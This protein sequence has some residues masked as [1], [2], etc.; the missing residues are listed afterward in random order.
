[1]RRFD[2]RPGLASLPAVAP[3]V[4]AVLAVVQVAWPLA[5][6]SRALLA[7]LTVVALAA[8]T[9]LLTTDAWG[10]RRAGIVAAAVVT[11]SLTVEAVGI[12]TGTPFGD[13]AYGTALR[14]MILGVPAIVPLAWFGMALPAYAVARRAAAGGA[15]RVVLGALALTAWDLFLD[16]QMLHE[17]FW[18]WADG[19]IFRGIPISNLTGWLAVGV[20]VMILLDGVAPQRWRTGPLV[21]VYAYVAVMET[22]GFAVF[23][24]DPLLALVG[25]V[26][27][28]LP[29]AAAARGGGEHGR[30]PDAQGSRGAEAPTGPV[31]AVDG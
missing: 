3:A 30:A 25:G 14:P 12:R 18:T 13:Y 16:P 29:L 6:G 21:V 5:P 31:T 2:P 8:L 15:A 24:G 10:L 9:L 20:F 1:M 27:M 19:G 26:A 11:G 23:L 4:W 7:T 22:V 17:G 28:G